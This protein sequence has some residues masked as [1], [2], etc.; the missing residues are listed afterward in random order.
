MINIAL[1]LILLKEVFAPLVMDNFLLFRIPD[2]PYA[3]KFIFPWLLW[4]AFHFWKI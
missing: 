3:P 2:S 4:L 1:T